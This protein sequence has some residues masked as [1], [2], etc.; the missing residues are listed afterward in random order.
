MVLGD[1][2]V[3]PSLSGSKD[4]TVNSRYMSKR[5]RNAAMDL[6]TVLNNGSIDDINHTMMIDSIH[7]NSKHNPNFAGTQNSLISTTAND[8][9]KSH[10]RKH[11]NLS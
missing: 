6:N 9:S 11:I 8:F 3:P 4:Q 1:N 2:S 5:N 7:Q 10:V